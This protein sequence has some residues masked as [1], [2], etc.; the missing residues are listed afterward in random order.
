VCFSSRI[1][2]CCIMWR[3]LPVNTFLCWCVAAS[4]RPTCCCHPR[5]PHT[6]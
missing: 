5:N 3:S 2:L 6:R 1:S 4:C